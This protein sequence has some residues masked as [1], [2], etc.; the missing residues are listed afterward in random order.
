MDGPAVDARISERT[1]ERV[2][3]QKYRQA[4]GARLTIDAGIGL[5]PDRIIRQLARDDVRMTAVDCITEPG[6][7]R[8]VLLSDPVTELKVRESLAEAERL[9]RHPATLSQ[10]G[11]EADERLLLQLRRRVNALRQLVQMHP[12]QIFNIADGNTLDELTDAFCSLAE[13]IAQLE[14]RQEYAP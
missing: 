2:T 12:E 5:T 10:P 8:E 1:G 3:A 13:R 9:T 11:T 7:L 4:I 6:F 14:R